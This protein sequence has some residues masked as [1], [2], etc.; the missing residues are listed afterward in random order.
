MTK[1]I[2]SEAKLEKTLGK[3]CNLYKSQKRGYN[4]IV[5]TGIKISTSTGK[6]V[7][8]KQLNNNNNN[9][10][11]IN[12]KQKKMFHTSIMRQASNTKLRLF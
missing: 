1:K 11:N 3:L 8:D 4:D 12:Y 9:K 5:D 6:Q 2:M 10:R 7:R